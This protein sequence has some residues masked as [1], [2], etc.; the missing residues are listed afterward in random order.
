[1]WTLI[2]QERAGA[3]CDALSRAH[4]RLISA[5]GVEALLHPGNPLA[6]AG[7]PLPAPTEAP[8]I[9][10]RSGAIEPDSGDEFDRMDA[11]R[12]T[13]SGQ[14]RAR[15]DDAWRALGEEARARG[16]AL[17]LHPVAGDVFGDVPGLRA[18]PG[19]GIEGIV[20]EPVRLL[21]DPM[22]ADAEDHL[23]R[24]VEA[25]EGSGLVRTTLVTDRDAS[26]RRVRIGEG[27]LGGAVLHAVIRRVEGLAPVSVLEGERIERIER[28]A[29]A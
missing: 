8:A 9:A 16:V 25:V 20:F 14:G 24:L 7:L 18:L 13:W 10:V 5:R 2:E 12:R 19:L 15:F 28:I 29:G 22:L 23:A 26:G 6:P 27:L 3:P 17:W 11:A 21:T 4:D 1:M